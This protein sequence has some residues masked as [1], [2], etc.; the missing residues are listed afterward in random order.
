MLGGDSTQ[1]CGNQDVE[2][3]SCFLKQGEDPLRTRPNLCGGLVCRPVYTCIVKKLKLETWR[4]VC[5]CVCVCVYL[6]QWD[7]KKMWVDDII[8]LFCVLQVTP[9]ILKGFEV[10]EITE[11]LQTPR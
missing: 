3:V 10:V 11:L 4:C 7:V 8:E 1:N 6:I 2:L 5:V 9:S